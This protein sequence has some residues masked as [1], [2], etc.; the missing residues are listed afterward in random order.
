M[1]DSWRDV[2]NRVRI[3]PP[4][5][6]AHALLLQP[7]TAWVAF[8]LPGAVIIESV[9]LSANNG[10]PLDSALKVAGFLIELSGLGLVAVGLSRTRRLF[11]RPSFPSRVREWGRNVRS[12]ILE[13]RRVTAEAS[14]TIVFAS[15]G[16]ATVQGKTASMTIEQRIE[17]LERRAVAAEQK[18]EEVRDEAKRRVDETR[19]ALLNEDTEIRTSVATLRK[20]LE[21]F[22]VGGLDLEGMG[23]FWLI[24]GS[25]LSTFYGGIAGCPV[26]QAFM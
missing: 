13:G 2:F 15:T 20:Q 18:I 11:G 16:R 9:A 23:L 25:I 8:L 4:R 1:R 7:W 24:V 22:S 10:W 3:A 6:F 12:L 14:S 5:R 17:E 19:A 21:D 26:W